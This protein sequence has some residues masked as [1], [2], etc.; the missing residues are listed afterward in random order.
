MNLRNKKELAARTFG[1]GKKRIV[2]IESRKD[3]IKDAIT[4]QDMRDLVASGAIVIKQVK[5]RRIIERKRSRS[6]GNIRKIINKRKQEYV[7]ITRK[8]RAYTKGIISKIN[9]EELKK[10]RKKIRSREFK[11]KIDIKKYV[12]DLGWKQEIFA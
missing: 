11:N 12:E 4:K 9:K 7:A 2:F 6:T 8:L 1:I 5:G 10:I 3:E